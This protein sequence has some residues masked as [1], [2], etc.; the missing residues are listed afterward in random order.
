MSLR[1][2]SLVVVHPA[3]VV[4]LQP[5]SR[6]ERT[7]AR[8]RRSGQLLYADRSTSTV[9]AEWHP[10]THVRPAVCSSLPGRH[11]ELP[12]AVLKTGVAAMV[13]AADPSALRPR[14]DRGIDLVQWRS[15]SGIATHNVGCHLLELPIVDGDPIRVGGQW[16]NRPNQ[17]G[18]YFWQSTGRHIWYESALE[19]VCLVALD[20][21][22]QIDKIAAQPLRL[23]FRTGAK[24]VRH[25]PDFFAVHRS[26]D[27]VVYDV[28]PLARMSAEARAQF[29][30]TARV[31]EMVGWRHVVLNE[32]D[33]TTATNLAF[34]RNTR[35]LRCHPDL[36]TLEQVANVFAGGRTL[37]EAREMV[38][39]RSPALAMP[40]IKHLIW[41]RL[42]AVDLTTRLDF[43][44]VARTVSNWED[45]RCCA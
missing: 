9:G 33:P 32:P 37:G 26:G 40:A 42:L 23:L 24:A 14:A 13:T 7:P 3:P 35:H 2:H 10:R 4:Q 16:Q 28:K 31:C 15:P 44:T 39:R 17:H 29:A 36:V 5:T 38:S 27:Q 19:A 18:L 21:S 12:R 30:E 41:H 25:D 1:S 43:D 6:I 22:G 11:G 34:L 20:Q 8:S 45:K